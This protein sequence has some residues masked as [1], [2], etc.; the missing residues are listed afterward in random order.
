MYRPVPLQHWNPQIDRYR[1]QY[2]GGVLSKEKEQKKEQIRNTGAL[3]IITP[4]RGT[5][6]PAPV[7]GKDMLRLSML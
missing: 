6:G 5:Q 2:E 3:G 1:Y 7:I 4:L